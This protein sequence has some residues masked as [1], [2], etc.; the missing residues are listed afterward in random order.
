MANAVQGFDRRLKSIGKNRARLADGYV[1]KVGKDGLIVFRPKRRAGGFPIV[2]LALLI[3]G[4]FAFK[5][6]ILAHLGANTFE[7]RL[8]ELAQGSVVEQTGAWIM[9][10][11]AVSQTIA[12][13]VRP[14]LK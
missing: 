4:F 9:Q 3:L 12:Q 5:G 1:S 6:L 14:F 8:A 13:Q 10:P 2:G 7:A 11:D